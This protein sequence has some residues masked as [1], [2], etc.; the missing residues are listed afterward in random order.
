MPR[1]DTIESHDSP[2]VMGP[3]KVEDK[4]NQAEDRFS[5]EMKE[6]SKFGSSSLRAI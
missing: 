4:Q 5:T 1:D 2:Q 6:T 3:A